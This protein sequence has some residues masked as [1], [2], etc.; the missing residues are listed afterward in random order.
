LT[1][2]RTFRI[3]ERRN[4][5]D[6][7]EA[8]TYSLLAFAYNSA[9]LDR[10]NHEVIDEIADGVRNGASVRVVGYTD[11]TGSDDANQALSLRRAGGVAAALRSRLRERGVR[12]VNVETKGL[13]VDDSRYDNQLPEGRVLSREVDVIV[14]QRAPRTE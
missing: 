9:E 4:A 10:R 5:A 2:E 6:D 13:G 14:E 7:R 8:V 3:V 11:R 12:D 1:L